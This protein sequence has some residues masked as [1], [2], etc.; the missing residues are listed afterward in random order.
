M[1]KWC[2]CVGVCIWRSEDNLRK[3]VLCFYHV[4]PRD[5]WTQVIRTGGRNLYLLTI[6]RAPVLSIFLI[7]LPIFLHIWNKMEYSQILCVFLCV[8]G[9]GVIRMSNSTPLSRGQIK[10]LPHW[11]ASLAN[12]RGCRVK[13]PANF[14]YQNSAASPFIPDII[15]AG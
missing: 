7:L 9:R 14:L 6:L 15:P 10:G 2:V 1:H 12:F 4:G 8:G 13:M 5:Y 3:P 11:D